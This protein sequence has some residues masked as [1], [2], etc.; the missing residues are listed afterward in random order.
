LNFQRTSNEIQPLG[1]E[2]KSVLLWE[3]I[4]KFYFRILMAVKTVKHIFIYIGLR[5]LVVILPV[6]K[7]RRTVSLI[8]V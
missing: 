1:E 5:V 8:P 2:S 3:N 7:I 4:T 6:P